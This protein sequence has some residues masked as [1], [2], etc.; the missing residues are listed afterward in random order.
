LAV[1]GRTPADPRG[2]V[3]VA[4]R[5]LGILAAAAALAACRPSPQQVAD[6]DDPLAALT[7]SA[8][9]KRYNSG[10]WR[11]QAR[12]DSAGPSSLWARALAY[13]GDDARPR[14]GLE[15]DGAKPNCGAVR[16]VTSERRQEASMRAVRA[17]TDAT[18]EQ[19]RRMQRDPAYARRVADSAY[20]AN[21]F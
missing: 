3:R 15:T 9:S 1:P 7:V 12:A 20:R 10:Y 17:R 14:P 19:W 8:E 13:C 6:G 5:L 16:Q 18:Q 4:S 2:G 21:R 11:E